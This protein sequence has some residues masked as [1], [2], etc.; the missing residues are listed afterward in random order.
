MR[1]EQV[2]YGVYHTKLKV[3]LDDDGYHYPIDSSDLYG[4]DNFN[5]AIDS[6]NNLV[7]S[8]NFN[9][10][11]LVIHRLVGSISVNQVFEVDSYV[12]DT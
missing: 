11:D 3:Y 12:Q 7:K 8:H 4:L 1:H 5:E 6:I 2:Y 9:P 10:M